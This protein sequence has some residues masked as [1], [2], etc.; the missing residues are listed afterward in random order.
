[1]RFDNL[2][3]SRD[4]IDSFE[5]FKGLPIHLTEFSTSYTPK[6]VIH[7]TNINAAFL[8]EQ[9]SRLGDM[10]EAYSYWTFGDVFEELGVPF[11]LFHGGFGLVAY[12]NIPKPTFWTFSFYKKL[13]LAGEKCVHRDKNSIIVKNDIGDG[14]AGILWNIDEYAFTTDIELP[15]E[16]ADYKLVTRTVDEE[17]CNPL[18]L[19]HDIGEPAYPTKEDIKLIKSAAY[20][21]LGSDVLKPEDGKATISIEVKRNGVVYFEVSEREFTPDRGYD[22][23]K[24]MT[25]H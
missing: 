11:S 1:M 9:L 4:I 20:P 7:D 2:Q 23:N 15:L 22:Y 3:S 8:A 24:V 17:C 10:N 14:Y 5:E 13:K 19:W 18:K 6:G 21:L 16:G 25:F 12:G